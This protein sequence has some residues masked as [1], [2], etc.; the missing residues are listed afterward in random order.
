MPRRGST[1]G[2]RRRSASPT[3]PPSDA[4]GDTASSCVPRPA[5]RAPC[6]ATPVRAPGTAGRPGT[7]GDYLLYTARQM[8]AVDII[9]SKRDGRAL[10]RDEIRFFV[11]GV[12]GGTLPH[13]QAAAL[14]SAILVP[15][16]TFGE[17]TCVT[18][19]IVHSGV[20]VDL[21]GSARPLGHKRI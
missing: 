20:R 11:D 5:A 8:R 4:P 6:A 19:A 2:S 10:S 17:N 15:G 3:R 13:F 21:R 14:L 18:D 1:R 12:T 7:R 9:S 16:M